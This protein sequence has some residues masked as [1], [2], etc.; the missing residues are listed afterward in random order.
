VNNAGEFQ[1]NQFYSGINFFFSIKARR[2]LKKEIRA[3]FEAY[4]KTGLKL[5]HVNAHNHMHL[6]PTVFNLII[7]IGR[8]YELTAIRIP[9]EPPLNS[10]IDNKKEFIIRYLRW[11][12]FMLLIFPM[13]RKC[14]KNN[15]N[16]NDTIYGLHDSGHMNIEKLIRIISHITNGITEIYTHPATKKNYNIDSASNEYEFEAE[17]KALIHA[18]T[19]RAIDKFNIKLSGFNS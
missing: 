15:I 6:H 11:I 4:R 18:R 8:D 5:D 3:Q 13:K 14:I 12:F 1:T 10:I 16:F 17:F 2:Q 19:K 7:E 9:N